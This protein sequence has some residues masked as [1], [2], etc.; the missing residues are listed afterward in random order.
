MSRLRRFLFI[1]FSIV[2]VG[3]FIGSVASPAF[4]VRMKATAPLRDALLPPPTPVSIT[5]LYSTEKEEWLKDVVADF[6][7]DVPLINGHPIKV[8]LK[9]LGSRE[10]YLAVLDGSEQPDVISPA[11]SLQVSI[12]EN[13]ST[14]KFDHPIVRAADPA[15]CRSV[16]NSPLVLVAWKERADVLW[17]SDPGQTLW[18][19]LH[20][21]VLDNKGWET[22]GHPD[23]GYIK[24]GHTS[25]LSSNSGFM[26]ILL[27]TYAYFNKTSGLNAAELL[28][29]NDYQKW[30]LDLETTIGKFG[31]STGNYMKE[32]V[33]YGPSMYDL[34]TV[35]EATAIEQAQNALGRY[36]EL[37]VYYP[38]VNV[39]S[40]HPF[41]VLQADWVTPEKT[42][43]AQQF[44]DF[45]LG[46]SAQEKALLKYGFRPSDSTISLNQAGS[47]F[48]QYAANGVRTDVGQLV[49]LPDGNTLQT[50]LDFW[51]RNIK[52]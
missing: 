22:Y 8:N 41:C 16:V 26:T 37:R 42:Q 27:M 44:I 20:D 50:L 39:M 21:A 43:A 5:V 48:Q 3:T 10:M 52:P 36:G 1:V 29:N 47:P 46:K 7:N 34:I 11:S 6:E 45:L 35:Y 23:W 2:V 28:G 13:L 25:P 33:A 40:D 32:M 51:S 4:R 9:P 18:Q 24:F 38:P 49:A 19:K 14:A 17:G 31:D 15:V 30:L 12:L